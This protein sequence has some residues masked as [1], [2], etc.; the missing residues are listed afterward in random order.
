MCQDSHFYEDSLGVSLC[1]G[2]LRCCNGRVLKGELKSL[3]TNGG[4]SSLYRKSGS[5][6]AIR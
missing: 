1:Q 5:R 3:R 6:S 4:R 2:V